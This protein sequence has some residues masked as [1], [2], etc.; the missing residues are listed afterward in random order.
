MLR[1]K[2]TSSYRDHLIHVSPNIGENDYISPVS[3]FS[4][5]VLVG[6]LATGQ[7][8]ASGIDSRPSLLELYWTNASQITV[9]CPFPYV[10]SRN[11]EERSEIQA[12][13]Q[14]QLTPVYAAHDFTC[15]WS[16][17]ICSL[18]PIVSIDR[19]HPFA[20]CGSLKWIWTEVDARMTGRAA[21]LT[22]ASI[23]SHSQSSD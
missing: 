12:E 19:S 2:L 22:V 20:N 23:T 18:M 8:R 21:E 1:T 9:R 11:D 13:N 10:A 5:C 3:R 4:T 17:F 15:I 6:N 14:E 7:L 16:L